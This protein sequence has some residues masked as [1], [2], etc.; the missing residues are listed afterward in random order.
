MR[1]RKSCSAHKRIAGNTCS[2]VNRKD[3]IARERS[4]YSPIL[5]CALT[6]EYKTMGDKIL[7]PCKCT[8]LVLSKTKT[9]KLI[10]TC[11]M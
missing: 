11:L 2:S 10:P 8:R 9:F 1:S 5:L 6:F 4:I 7:I 3:T